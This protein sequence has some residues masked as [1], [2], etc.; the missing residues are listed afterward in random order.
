MRKNDDIRFSSST[1]KI[2]LSSPHYPLFN[3]LQFCSKAITSKLLGAR[4]SLSRLVGSFGTRSGNSNLCSFSAQKLHSATGL[5][6]GRS[7]LL[8][9]ASLSLAR[10]NEPPPFECSSCSEERVPVG[11]SSLLCSVSLSL[12]QPIDLTQSG[13]DLRETQ[14]QKGHSVSRHDEERVLISEVLVRNKDGEEL[15]RKDLEM[16][17]LAALKASRANSALTVREVQEDVHR[18]IDS[19]YFCS[20][21]PVAVDTRDGIRLVF[22]VEPNQEFHG[23]VCE[24]ANVLPTKFLEDSFRDG[25]AVQEKW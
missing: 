15:E 2:P 1:I 8:C 13:S 3:N 16:E 6:V 18:I 11:K 5:L 4:H 22:Q 14:Q 20:C 10:H 7:S 12:S 23:L 21:M 17:A 19:G 9:S 24:G 25:Y